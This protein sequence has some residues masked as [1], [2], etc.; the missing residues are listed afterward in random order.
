M[1]IS[2]VRV[3]RSWDEGD[4]NKFALRLVLEGASNA[5][6]GC[7]KQFTSELEMLPSVTSELQILPSVTS[8]LQMLPSVTS[9]LQMLPSV[10]SELQMLPSVTSKLKMLQSVFFC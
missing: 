1:L 5:S 7:Q 6:A 10:T 8:K 4:Q 3:A 9:K 2:F